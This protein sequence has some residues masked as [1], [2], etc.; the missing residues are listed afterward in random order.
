MPHNVASDQGLH[1]LLLTPGV[2]RHHQQVVFQLDMEMVRS[3]V[4][5]NILGKFGNIIFRAKS[6][7]IKIKSIICKLIPFFLSS[8]A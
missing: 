2:N 8:Y 3:E 7:G 4:C 6:G 1:S 5:P